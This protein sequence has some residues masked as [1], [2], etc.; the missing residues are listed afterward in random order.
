MN[1]KAKIQWFTT[2]STNKTYRHELAEI[3]LKVVLNTI[4]QTN[5]QSNMSYSEDN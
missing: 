3:L 2:S 1:I 4:T 5:K